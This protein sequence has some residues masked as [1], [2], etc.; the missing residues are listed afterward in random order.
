MRRLNTVRTGYL[1]VIGGSLLLS[2]GVVMVLQAV[3]SFLYSRHSAD[4]GAFTVRLLHWMINHIG[5][6]PLAVILFTALSGSFFL[7]RSQKLSDDFK[8][9]LRASDELAANGFFKELEV[10]T[11]G[12]LGRLAANLRKLNKGQQTKLTGTAEIG[13]AD[14]E[15]AGWSSEESMALILRMKTLLRLLDELKAAEGEAVQV[16]AMKREAAGLERFLVNLIAKC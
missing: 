4:S 9:L 11:G 15:E 10:S 16:D 12:E 3:V 2:G 7:L 6:L 5:R 13:S 1:Y 8:A 14:A